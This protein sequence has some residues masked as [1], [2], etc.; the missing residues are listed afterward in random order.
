MSVHLELK[1]TIH[2]PESNGTQLQQISVT[3]APK[4]MQHL[5]KSK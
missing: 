1:N 4:M 5:I 2:S 3:N